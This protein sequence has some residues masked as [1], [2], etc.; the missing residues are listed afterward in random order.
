MESALPVVGVAM[1]PVIQRLRVFAR[2]EETLLLAGPTGV[3]KSRL[4]RWCH[5]E[6][7]RGT[8][9]FETLSLLG[10]PEELQLGELFGWKKGAFTGAIRDNPGSVARAQGGTL[11]IDEIDKLSLRA[12]A[13]LLQFLD[14]HTFRSLGE[15]GRERAA[16]VRII[17]GTNVD[18]R[19][20]VREGRFRED[21]YYRI[22]VLPVRVPPLAERA[23]EIA[24]WAHYMVQRRHLESRHPGRV[25]LAE[26]AAERLQVASW[27][28]NLRQLDNI[29][30][31][32]YALAAALPVNETR[33]ELV[34]EH[35]HVEAALHDE[36]DGEESLVTLLRRAASAFVRES[37]RRRCEGR[38]ELDLDQADAF[39]SFVLGS[40]IQMAGG[41]E[42]AV[43]W[44]GKGHLLASRNHHRLLRRESKKLKSFCR[45][46]G[47]DEDAV[48]AELWP[49]DRMEQDP[50]GATAATGE[51]E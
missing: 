10:V 18:L 43:Q 45:A 35:E 26:A 32:A 16:D 41:R 42:Q 8:R 17:V 38:L 40:A 15:S 51:D 29:V 37:G 5:D 6:S 22:N 25:Q 46:L 19:G 39:R 30:R 21:L 13:G 7:R 49:A 28:G 23:D 4:A 44:L 11:F 36:G 12:Q 47:L 20:S 34:V 50:E 27:P 14:S 9:T 24:L 33:T 31:R 1:T 48:Q 3:G 2:Q